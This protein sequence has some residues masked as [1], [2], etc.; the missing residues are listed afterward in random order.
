MGID[1]EYY[2][3]DAPDIGRAYEDAIEDYKCRYEEDDSYRPRYV[4]SERCS[5]VWNGSNISFKKVWSGYTFTDDECKKLLNGEVIEIN[6]VIFS[7]TGHVYCVKGK[8]EEGE[9]KGKKFVG[10]NPVEKPEVVMFKTWCQYTFTDEELRTLVAGEEIFIE[11]FVSKEGREFSAYVQYDK[12]LKKI[13]PR[14]PSGSAITA[15]NGA[16]AKKLYEEYCGFDAKDNKQ[17]ANVSQA[18]F[19][20]V[21]RFVMSD[22]GQELIKKYSDQNFDWSSLIAISDE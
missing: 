15:I 17:G 6:G 2:F 5:G 11:K 9:Y 22:G 4:K 7:K 10:F 16:V 1:W 3:D 12:E 13:V 8:L 18:D 19:L 21:I 14:F 20:R